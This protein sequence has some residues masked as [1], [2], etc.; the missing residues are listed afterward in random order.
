M[1][2]VT[3]LLTTPYEF[4]RDRESI[5]EEGSRYIPINNVTNTY[6]IYNNTLLNF[7]RRAFSNS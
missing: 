7:S 6:M 2:V 1:G 3:T 4:S 5:D